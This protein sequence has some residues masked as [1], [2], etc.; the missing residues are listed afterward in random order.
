MLYLFIGY[1]Y[2]E[3]EDNEND[4]TDE[5]PVVYHCVYEYRKS[6]ETS[7][8]SFDKLFDSDEKERE[9]NDDV[10][11]MV[12]EDVVDHKAGEGVEKG[13]GNG[14][15]SIFDKA[16]EVEIG[17]ESGKRKFKHEKRRHKIREPSIREGECQPEERTEQQIEA[18]GADEICAEIGVPVPENISASYRAVSELVEGD[19]LNVIVAVERKDTLINYNGDKEHKKRHDKGDTEGMPVAFFL[20]GLIDGSKQDESL[21]QYIGGTIMDL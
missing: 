8:F 9:E 1:S 18:V 4:L 21:L 2:A 20:H 7:A 6:E 16:L 15:V 5:E 17:E 11:E 3:I 19:L 12:K 14:K 10:M 13:T